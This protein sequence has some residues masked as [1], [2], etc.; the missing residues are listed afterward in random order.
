MHAN[1]KKTDRFCEKEFEQSNNFFSI[2]LSCSRLI[3]PQ[4]TS[5]R[6]NLR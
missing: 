3:R 6:N 1:E 4:S 5:R 2:C